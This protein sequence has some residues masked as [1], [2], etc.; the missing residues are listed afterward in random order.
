MAIAVSSG[1]AA[2]DISLAVKNVGE[3]DEIITTPLTFVSTVHSIVHRGARPVLVDIDEKTFNLS[4]ERVRDFIKTNYEKTEKGLMS[5]RT[6]KILKG[7]IVVHYGGQAA[8]IDEF[9]EIAEESNLFIIEDAA[10][11]IGAKQN[12]IP[13]GKSKNPV[14]F[15]FYSNKNI[16]TGEGGMI[17][18]ND[19]SE[20]EKY[21]KLSL[22][23]ISKNNIERYK[24]GLPFYDVEYSGFKNN[25]TDIQAAMGIAQMRKIDYITKR[26]NE[27]AEKYDKLLSDVS[28]IQTPFIKPNN[29]SAR[30][31]YPILVNPD[32][33]TKRDEIIIEL[34]KKNIF[35]SVHF[36][37]V[38]LFSFYKEYFKSDELSDLK[39]S[40]NVF[41]REISLPIFPELKDEE[42]K[43][44]VE[45][46]KTILLKVKK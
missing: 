42:I 6:K 17:V 37:P 32:L 18:I 44:V 19:N 11:A 7:I 20:E 2:I 43:R 30:H 5:K 36:V 21:R 3:N 29:Y 28:E 46:L 4:P 31:L 40:E 27:I 16:T 15:S 14:C 38:H 22:H 23:G 24:T 41:S 8:D 45:S 10:H 33:K 13:I 12:N 26:R 35:P 1:T 25:L 39:I 34:R 9:N